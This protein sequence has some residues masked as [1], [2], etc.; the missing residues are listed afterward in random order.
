L[1]VW[2][3]LLVRMDRKVPEKLGE[4]ETRLFSEF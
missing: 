4:E 2:G 1:G 3:D